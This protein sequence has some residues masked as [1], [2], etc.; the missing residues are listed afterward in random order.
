MIEVLTIDEA[1][2]EFPGRIP[3]DRAVKRLSRQGKWPHLYRVP[4]LRPQFRRDDLVAFLNA[5]FGGGEVT[6]AETARAAYL[7]RVAPADRAAEA[8]ARAPAEGLDC[9]ELA[10]TAETHV[11]E[12]W[13]ARWAAF[14]GP[15]LGPLI[16]LASRK[17]VEDRVGLIVVALAAVIN[18]LQPPGVGWRVDLRRHAD[19]TP[20]A[21]VMT[22]ADTDARLAIP[23]RIEGR[24]VRVGDRRISLGSS[25]AGRD[26]LRLLT[27]AAGGFFGAARRAH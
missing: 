20:R 3:E 6:T 5:S 8:R 21:M 26:V 17:R 27:E 16:G 22:R 23:I 25:N 4:G 19:D 24:N 14:Y 9:V 13:A 1:R 2:A 15:L 18:A 10:A 11:V 7:H 12:L